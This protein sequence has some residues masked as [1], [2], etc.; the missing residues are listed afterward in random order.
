MIQIVYVDDEIEDSLSGARRYQERLS[1]AEDVQCRLVPP[2]EWSN[3]DEFVESTPDLYLIDYQLSMVQPNGRKADYQGSTLAAEIRARLPDCPI[4][5]VTRQLVLDQLESQTRRQI[6]GHMQTYDGLILKDRMDRDLEG[7]Q[8]LLVSIAEGFRQ[9]AGMTDKTWQSLLGAMG[10]DRDEGELLQEAAPPLEKGVW[11]VTEAAGWIRDVVLSFPGILYDAVNAATRLG[12]SEEAFLLEE[13]QGLM[14]PAEYQGIFA[15]FEGR[16]WKGRLF[17]VATALAADEGVH[18]PINRAF[19]KAF[20]TRYGTQLP[21][22]EC[23]WDHMPLADWVCYVLREPVKIRHSLRYYPDNRPSVMDEARVSFRAVRES[24]EFDEQ[25]V[26]S[27]GS[28][29]LSE[30]EELREA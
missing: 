5:L 14:R 17:R 13:V 1:R 21:P 30:I 4:V 25:L 23:V 2:P 22:A 28:A 10:A 18:E 9:L 20:Q 11:I 12:I 16:W 27:E 6:T 3:L 24:S 8:R 29:L 15:P 26:D 7:T 19:A